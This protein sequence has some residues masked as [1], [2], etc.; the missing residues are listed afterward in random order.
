MGAGLVS[1]HVRAYTTTNHFWQ[2]FSSVPA[3][4]DGNCFAFGG[5]FGD[6][7]QRVIQV[8]GLLVDIASGQA[9][10]D[11][12]LL[13][14]DVQRAG[15]GQGGGQRLGTAHAAQTGRQHPFTDQAAVVVLATGL[16]EG[17][18]G[19]LD[20]ALAADVDPAAGGHLAV[21]GQAFGV[22]FVEV[23]PRGPVRHQVGVGDQDPW[24]VAVGFEHA[25]RLARLHQQGF[26]IVE[27]GQAFD[28]FVVALPVTRCP[29]N[30]AIHHQLGRVLGHLR[31]EVVHQHPQRRFGHPAFSSELGATGGA[32]FTITVTGELS[33]RFWGS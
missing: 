19:A 22:E 29:S 30:T 1:D 4:G 20:D 23:L 12:A 9:E 6:T 7:G 18:V 25:D 15:A 3:Q 26:V 17:F 24:R 11:A 32:D 10:I 31:V 8:R 33:R 28:D 16:D 5:V 21:H 2:Q 27:V 14:F 13:A